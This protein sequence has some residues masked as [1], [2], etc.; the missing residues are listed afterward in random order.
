MAESHSESGQF[1]ADNTSP[2]A[3][4]SFRLVFVARNGYISLDTEK[5]YD[6]NA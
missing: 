6:N 4:T 2:F 3:F 1:A 5:L